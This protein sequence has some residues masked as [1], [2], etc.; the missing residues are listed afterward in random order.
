M[1]PGKRLLSLLF[2]VAF[3][4][5]VMSNILEP[6]V[7]KAQVL[8][9]LNKATITP[10]LARLANLS[11]SDFPAMQESG[12]IRSQPDW[13]RAAGYQ[14]GRTWSAGQTASQFLKL[15]ELGFLNFENLTLADIA[16]LSQVNYTLGETALSSFE[17]LD[18]QSLRDLVGAVPK[19]GDF[20]VSDVPPIQQLLNSSG[21]ET[22]GLTISEVLEQYPEAGELLLNKIELSEFAFTDIPNLELANII[23]FQGWQDTFL[24]GVP[25]LSTV[26]FTD[27]A[28]FLFSLGTLATV[29]VT[30]ST[31]ETDS[32]NTISGSFKEGFS[33]PCK[34]KCAYVELAGAPPLFD[35]SPVYGKKW[36]S[37]KY[38]KVK[39]GSGILGSLNGGMEPTGRHPF[40]RAFKV[41]IWEITESTGT[42]ETA[43]FFRTCGLGCSPYIFGPVPFLTFHE[44]DLFFLVGA[45]NDEGG[46]TQDSTPTEANPTASGVPPEIKEPQSQP[47]NEKPGCE[48]SFIHPAPGYRVPRPGG[49]F[50]ACR[51]LG[52]CRRK[53]VG[54]DVAAPIGT[55]VKASDDGIV[56]FVGWMQGYGLAVDIKHCSYSTRYAHL[57]EALVSQGTK[58]FQGD[59][60]AESGNT[61]VGSGPHLH[62]EIREGGRM[63]SPIDPESFIKF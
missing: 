31:A 62:F 40:G 29:D 8:P 20:Q 36:L 42:V 12:E 34:E 47:P 25:G 28:G 22:K 10:D 58:V 9:G 33:V 60:V 16:S 24:S 5:T 15:G 43:L 41:V 59:V 21:I 1:Y 51:P 37:G 50:G 23:D 61:G 54:T 30:Y 19:L 53:H 14:L 56:S 3:C 46:A 18:R 39:G 35:K 48:G 7:T 45:L 13:D 44:S 49:E 52:S 55:P 4:L 6:S 2:T 26:P 11:F 32:D 63:G 17:L 38:Q 27:M 57:N